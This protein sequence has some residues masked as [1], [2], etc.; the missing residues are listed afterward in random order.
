MRNGVLYK[1]LKTVKLLFVVPAQ[2][3]THVLYRYHDEMGHV[4]INKVTDLINKTYWFPHINN[5]V[6]DHVQNCLKCI[7]FSPKS[8]PI[9]GFLHNIPKSSKPFKMVHID[10]CGPV[11]RNSSKKHIFVV[12]DACTKFVKLYSTKTTATKEVIKALR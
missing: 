3:E 7:T 6:K 11:D 5:K 8:G 12:I 4:G 1:K 9:E 2:M 10:H